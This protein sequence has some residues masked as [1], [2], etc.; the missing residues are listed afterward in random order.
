M[1]C[2]KISV[3]WS[4]GRFQCSR[5]RL[6]T[7]PAAL[8]SAGRGTA[9]ARPDGPLSL[10]ALPRVADQ[11]PVGAQPSAAS[12]P[13]L[14]N[15]QVPRSVLTLHF[16]GCLPATGGTSCWPLSWACAWLLSETNSAASEEAVLRTQVGSGC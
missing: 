12:A 11:A 4:C 6:L 7:L 3:K 9:P 5:Q 10:P 15:P 14:H 1:D 8:S 16:C 13:I 2:I